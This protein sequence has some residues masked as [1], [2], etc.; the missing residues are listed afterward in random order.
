MTRKREN[1][2]RRKDGRWEARVSK[3]RENG[4]KI[5][6]SL[7]GKS[8][9]EVKAKKEEYYGSISEVYSYIFIVKLDSSKN[10]SFCYCDVLT[11]N[12]ELYFDNI[13]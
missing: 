6:R 9:T 13:L 1:I 7:Y 8:Y 11:N 5:Y 4:N 10:K 3:H 12:V 2:F